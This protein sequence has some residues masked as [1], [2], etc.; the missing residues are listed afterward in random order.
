[1]AGPRQPRK[2]K[3]APHAADDLRRPISADDLRRPG[4]AADADKLRREARGRLA[5]LSAAAGAASPSAPVPEELAAAV[6][7]LRVHQIELEMQNEELRRAQHEL[8]AQREKY[9]ELFDLAPV[10]YLTIGDKGIVGDANLTAAR[11]LG[12]ER[13]RLVGRSFSAFVLAADR[14]S[15][16][17]LRTLLKRTGEPR[18]CEL[19]LQRPG[20]A[21]M[22]AL[23]EATAAQDGEGA[24]A[25]RLTLSDIS[26]RKQAE[27]ALRAS[28][29]LYRSL[30]SASPDDITITDL[31]GRIRMVSPAALTM[32]GYEREDQ[33]LGRAL[34]EFI[35][36]ED[37]E[38]VQAGVAL[39][40]QG[41]FPGPGEYRGLRADGSTFAIEA[42]AELVRDAHEQP[43]GMIFIVRDIT[44]RMLAAEALR[45][46]EERFRSLLQDARSVSV[47]G[48]G[49]D[50]TTRYWNQ[51]SERLYG[52]SAQEAMGRRLVD[53]IIPPEM[54]GDV[55]QAIRRM[56]ETGQPIPS[57]ELTL[58]RK[59]GSR[60]PV[61]SSH[62]IVQ[63]PGREQELF[64]IDI[65]LT[66]RKQAEEALARSAQELREQLHDTVKT[67]GAIVGLRDPY[68]AAHER[69]VTALAAAIAV[70]MGLDDEAREG[71]AFAAEVHD[72]GKIGVP[73]EILSKPGALS[74]VEYDLI[75]QH[76]EAGREL[77]GAIHF[78]QP[79]AEI[80]AQHQ[81]RLDG[82]GYPRGLKGEEILLEARIL[83]VADV[84]EAM[85]SH[86]P[87]RP[88]LGLEAALA[89][90]RSGA[91]VRYDAEAVAACERAFAGGFALDP[92]D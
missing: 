31:E 27:E 30:L 84:V 36:P 13:R 77:L 19:R 44:E 85:A 3:A 22:W 51:A 42:N 83:A 86:R 38:R 43:T 46:G 6:H 87:Y 52:Y 32:F 69:R 14:D 7:E 92:P 16:Y 28:E 35:V 70:E 71:L 63:I 60:V 88:S 54:R 47:Q 33:M 34:T 91:G 57:S 75:K 9:F 72:V 17:R 10:G 21:P 15:Y 66:E 20:G 41:V 39:M 90:V 68:T 81:E 40:H 59:D 67:M 8:D 18:T 58:R 76:P 80:V 64:C 56:A 24:P 73:A 74:E 48:Y 78:S 79:V 25:F 12:V 82:S 37:R 53:L 49:S 50:G 2:K 55:E 61:F 65:D 45:A 11:L 26:V 1:M 29:A 5:G 4:A 23:L 62:T 89:E